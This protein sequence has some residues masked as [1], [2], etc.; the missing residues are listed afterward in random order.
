[1]IRV[2]HQRL[3]VPVALLGVVVELDHQEE[4]QVRVEGARR[5]NDF[6]IGSQ[7]RFKTKTQLSLLQNNAIIALYLPLQLG[8]TLKKLQNIVGAH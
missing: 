2:E 5:D 7:N 3:V 4:A 8:L 6:G 1:M